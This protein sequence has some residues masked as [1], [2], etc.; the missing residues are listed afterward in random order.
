MSSSSP[1]RLPLSK[2]G[3]RDADGPT[4]TPN[5]TPNN[6]EDV[7]PTHAAPTGSISAGL[8]LHTPAPSPTAQQG[9]GVGGIPCLSPP[10]NGGTSSRGRRFRQTEAGTTDRGGSS[11]SPSPPPGGRDRPR[12]ATL[13]GAKS[14]DPIEADTTTQKPIGTQPSQLSHPPPGTVP[15]HPSSSF[16]PTSLQPEA[17]SPRVTHSPGVERRHHLSTAPVLLPSSALTLSPRYHQPGRLTG[18]GGGL[19]PASAAANANAASMAQ[20]PSPGV[21]AIVA[22]PVSPRGDRVVPWF[23]QWLPTPTHSRRRLKIAAPGGNPGADPSTVMGVGA[24]PLFPVGP[25]SPAPSPLSFGGATQG[26][27]AS[28]GPSPSTGRRSARARGQTVTF[29]ES[30]QVQAQLAGQGVVPG[31]EQQNQ[32]R[33]RKLWSQALLSK[34]LSMPLELALAEGEL[35]EGELELEEEMGGNVFQEEMGPRPWTSPSPFGWNAAVAAGALKFGAGGPEAESGAMTPGAPFALSVPGT[36]AKAVAVSRFRA[37][38]GRSLSRHSPSAAS[39]AGSGASLFFPTEYEGAQPAVSPLVPFWGPWAPASPSPSPQAGAPPQQD[40][41][42]S[43]DGAVFAALPRDRQLRL[44]RVTPEPL[45]SQLEWMQMYGPTQAG[46]SPTASNAPS[47]CQSVSAS[48]CASPSTIKM[49]LEA[50]SPRP[51]TTGTTVKGPA[52][53]GHGTSAGDSLETAATASELPP[54]EVLM[55]SEAKQQQRRISVPTVTLRRGST[56]PV[57]EVSFDSPAGTAAA[58]AAGGKE[59]EEGNAAVT[60]TQSSAVSGVLQ[61]KPVVY[62]REEAETRT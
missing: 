58:A 31:H 61:E 26:S 43:Q 19:S 5:H 39:G 35:E 25:A 42:E 53:G 55:D 1:L 16:S 14:E 46:V 17:S 32:Q 3:G 13:P 9:M 52:I 15:L 24:V 38:G 48:P 40:W 6:Q 8:L 18:T 21:G 33:L 57:E 12:V 49:K 59:K 23:A 54:G 62:T 56:L 20:P 7:N 4:P 44:F 50:P 45:R 28:P 51:N 27:F 30:A 10:A 47:R 60:E 11:P 41:W 36:P 2:R 34:G 29:Q 37:E 22:I